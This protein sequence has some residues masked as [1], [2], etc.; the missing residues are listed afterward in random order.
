MKSLKDRRKRLPEGKLFQGCWEDHDQFSA[1]RN[2][3]LNV[4]YFRLQLSKLLSTPRNHK[5]TQ[6]YQQYIC[7]M[8]FLTA[9]INLVIFSC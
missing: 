3:R 7:W 4:T 6:Q 1:K 2:S 8:P 9:L 5:K